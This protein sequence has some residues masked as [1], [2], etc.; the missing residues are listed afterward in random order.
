[1]KMKMF[2]CAGALLLAVMFCG[3]TAS[4]QQAVAAAA[5]G[6]PDLTGNWTGTMIGYEHGVGFTDFTGYTITMSITD[7][8]GSL[9]E[10][11]S[12]RTRVDTGSGRPPRAP[13]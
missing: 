3:C 11:S 7:Q 10:S 6:T 2:L 13:A 1:M 9:R 4:S 8:T 12:S 5:P